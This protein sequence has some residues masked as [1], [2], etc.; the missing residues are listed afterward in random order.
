MFQRFARTECEPLHHIPTSND[1]TARAGRNDPYPSPAREDAHHRLSRC[2][3]EA[4]EILAGQ[5][6]G[7]EQLGVVPA[8]FG[9]PE[10]NQETS[11]SLLNARPAKDIDVRGDALETLLEEVEQ[12]RHKRGGI[13]RAVQR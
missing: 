8:R 3:D 9:F 2:P 7:D 12:I 4:P 10:I 6:Q 11:E 13:N 5:S 1:D